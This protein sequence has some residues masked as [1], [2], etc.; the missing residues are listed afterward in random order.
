MRNSQEI[1]RKMADFAN[2]L[3]AAN[4]NLHIDADLSDRQKHA[5][6]YWPEALKWTQEELSVHTPAFVVHA[7]SAE[8]V[9]T[10]LRTAT[11][12][13]VAV[14]PYGAGSGVVGSIVHERNY[15]CLSLSNLKEIVFD[16]ARAEV[17]AEAGVIGVDLE[18]AL[19]ARGR[20]LPHYPQSLPLASIGGLVAT[21]SSGTFSSKYGNIENFIV[22]LEVVLA[23]G[24]IIKTKNAPRSSTGPALAQLFAGSEGC[25]GIVTA[26]TLRTYPLSQKL[27]FEGIAFKTID[28]GLKAVR[29]ILDNGIMPAVIRLYDAKEA[30]HIFE[31]CRMESN[32]RALLILGFDG[33]PIVVDAERSEAGK[34]TSACF[35]ED[36][37][38]TPGDTWEQTRFD[39]SWLDRGN[40]GQFNFADAIEI[41]AGWPELDKIYHRV[42]SAITPHVDK[43]Y[44]H[45]SHFYINGGALYFIFFTSG[46]DADEGLSR[47]R[48]T[49]NTTL[50]IVH[51]LGG[52]ISHHHGIGEARK[53]WMTAEHGA[54]LTIL[55]KLKQAFDPKDILCP[56]KMGISAQKETPK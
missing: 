4:P 1:E 18:R 26:A 20:R 9:S 5:R 21:R 31:K 44:A 25:F 11:A 50:R 16:D 8:D 24:T 15:V 14:V 30:L 35:C 6:D 19:N 43:A 41:A 36:L 42:L 40:S 55:N 28:A 34:I 22:G 12:H 2:A 37:G 7:G 3:R 38:S 32:D 23:D 48:A 56:G 54:S 29:A 27:A 47:Y 45:F 49:W 51:E 17:T 52:S 39:A 33:N 13:N 53:N 10:I 46:K